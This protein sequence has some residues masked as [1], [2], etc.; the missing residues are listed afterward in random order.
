M[1]RVVMERRIP[2]GKVRHSRAQVSV[3]PVG[4]LTI[5]N[6]RWTWTSRGVQWPSGYGIPPF[7]LTAFT[8]WR[9][10][11]PG[12][13]KRPAVPIRGFPSRGASCVF[14]WA[15]IEWAGATCG[16]REHHE[17]VHRARIAEPTPGG[18]CASYGEW[19]HRGENEKPEV[20]N[21][22]LCFG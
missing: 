22:M 20:G 15:G 14:F 5:R 21:L 4:V 12:L 18:V 9:L 19:N 17:R 11:L 3:N 13:T 8:P 10:T 2:L 16:F 7:P 6:R 1:T